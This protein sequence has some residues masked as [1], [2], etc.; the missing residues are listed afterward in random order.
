MTTLA[1]LSATKVPGPSHTITDTVELFC[2]VGVRFV[3]LAVVVVMLRSSPS[4]LFGLVLS[5][6]AADVAT[7]VAAGV[8]SAGVFPFAFSVVCQFCRCNVQ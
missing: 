3:V 8:A 1:L 4:C 5:V 7:G 2:S 6:A